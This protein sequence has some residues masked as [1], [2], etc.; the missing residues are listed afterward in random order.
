[1]SAALE[2]VRGFFAKRRKLGAIAIVLILIE[3]AA[4]GTVAIAGREWI[5]SVSVAAQPAGGRAP[6]TGFAGSLLAPSIA[7]F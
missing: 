3:L 1:M 2:R 7:V 4:A 6:A 5:D